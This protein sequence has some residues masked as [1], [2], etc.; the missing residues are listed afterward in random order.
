MYL[1]EVTRM[2]GAALPDEQ[3]EGLDQLIVL[4][5]ARLHS[6]R[7][8]VALAGPPGA[9][10]STIASILRD[11]CV[12]KLRASTEIVPMDGFHFDDSVLRARNLLARKGASNTFDVGG[13][14]AL[15]RR[16]R[17]NTEDEIAGPVFDRA[18]EVS[19][20]GALIIT[21]LTRVVI[22]EGNY[23]LLDSPPWAALRGLFDISVR[24]RTPQAVLRRR[25]VDRW[26]SFGLTG[27]EIAKKVE[28]NDL[29]N[30][31]LVDTS[32]I[33]P[34]LWLDWVVPGR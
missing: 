2:R 25:L 14:V 31:E 5:G 11:R 27:E 30:G 32:S 1:A 29:P 33:A 26:L 17:A 19:R 10:K 21:P 28:G 12:D 16:I 18:L 13:L 23:L 9:G 20:A 34:D 22:V 4:I 15:L 7:L 24:I 6:H 3:L 8:I